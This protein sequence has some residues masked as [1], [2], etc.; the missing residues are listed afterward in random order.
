MNDP[1]EYDAS[2]D[3]SHR[4][5]R[6]TS[7]G[8]PPRR[9][10][11]SGPPDR[12]A[13]ARR[14]RVDVGVDDAGAD[15]VDADAFAGDLARQADGERVDRRLRR[16]V[17]DV[18]A[19]RARA[20]PP[21]TRRSRSRRRR[22]RAPSTSAAPLRART[23]TRRGRWCAKT[24]SSRAASICSTRVCFSRMPAL[25]TSA[26]SGPSCASTVSKSRTTS[27]SDA[28]SAPHRQRRP[29][30]RLDLRDDR[31]GRRPVL[32]VVHAHR[33]AALGRQ[34]RG[35]G[36]DAAAAAGHDHHLVHE[37]ILIPNRNNPKPGHVWY[38][39]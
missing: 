21:A 5:A 14:R 7:S 20:A 39:K 32:S 18:F 28:T 27:A 13:R 24:R 1:V 37:E 22:R 16:G 19:R 25:L 23:G 9:I 10:G 31:V 30:R 15:A 34:P 38:Q 12:R 17:V 29:A 2:S 3:S 8:S 35:R 33:V 26:V 11:T 6:A 36:A 4:I